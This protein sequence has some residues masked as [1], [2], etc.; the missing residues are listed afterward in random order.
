M[1][2]AK[3]GRAKLPSLLL[4]TGLVAV[5]LYAAFNSLKSP[6][7][8]VIYL[9]T[10]LTKTVSAFSLIK[11]FAIYELGLALWLAS[12]RHIKYAASLGAVTFTGMILS[13][14]GLMTI[15][16]RDVALIFMCLALLAL[17]A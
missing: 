8:W 17:E 14:L 7:D 15:V 4:R 1:K 16:F 10:V 6:E 13:N 2:T 12:G 11:I 5:L 9:P 3:F